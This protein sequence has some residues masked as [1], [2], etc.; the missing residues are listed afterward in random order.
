MLFLALEHLISPV[1]TNEPPTS[2]LH[3]RV[4][5]PVP[6]HT[7]H[8]RF[9]CPARLALSAALQVGELRPLRRLATGRTGL[10]WSGRWMG[11]SV[12]PV[13]MLYD[14]L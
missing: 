13:W 2:G 1:A 8:A 12:F 14:V 11:V 9:S 10:E 7:Y 3:S 5:L 4:P 6:T